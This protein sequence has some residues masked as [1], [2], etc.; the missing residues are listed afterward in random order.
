MNTLTPTRPVRNSSRPLQ[1]FQKQV[2]VGILSTYPPTQCGLATFS[3]ALVNGLRQ[4]GVTDIGVV[5]VGDDDTPSASPCVV[6]RLIPRDSMSVSRAAQ[7]LNRYDV[8]IVQHEYGIYGG[9]DGD[10]LLEVMRRLHAPVIVTLHTVLLQPTA[11]QKHVLEAVIDEADVAVTM[12][13]IARQR[14]L[15]VYTVDPSR[16][17]IIPHGATI[18]LPVAPSSGHSPLLLTWGLLGPGKGIEWVIEALAML[19]S[20]VPQVNYVIAG[21]THPKVKAQH[22]EQYRR[23]LQD[24]VRRHRLQDRVEFDSTYRT[25]DSLLDLIAR[26]TCVVLPYESIDQITSGV[27]V[28]AVTAGRPVVATAFPHAVELLSGGAGMLVPPRNPES[29][30]KAIRK[31]ATKPALVQLMAQRA[32]SL[33]P[34]HNWANVASAY[35]AVGESLLQSATLE[36]RS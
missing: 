7:L 16:V 33:A 30:S 27:L 34:M 1:P 11:H 15:A 14:L 31:I 20:D 5:S 21:Q 8:V 24:E 22:G 35:K 9:E 28:D 17:G 4:A 13:A 10:Q 18:P 12:T 29:L 23:F 25:V 2:S 26:S 6:G 3:A 19:G 36:A 32:A